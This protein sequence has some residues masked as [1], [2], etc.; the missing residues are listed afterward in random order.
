MAQAYAANSKCDYPDGDVNRANVVIPDEHIHLP[1]PHS[2]KTE[3]TFKIT[4]KLAGITVARKFVGGTLKPVLLHNL[5]GAICR[6]A[7]WYPFFNFGLRV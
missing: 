5:T 7:K 2:P 1:P 6:S 4:I 3:R